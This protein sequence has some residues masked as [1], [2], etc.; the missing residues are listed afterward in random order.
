MDVCLFN[1]NKWIHIFLLHC[2]EN[3]NAK[4]WPIFRYEGNISLVF[5]WKIKVDWLNHLKIFDLML[6][7]CLVSLDGVFVVKLFFE[8]TIIKNFTWNLEF[9]TFSR[10]RQTFIIIHVVT[11]TGQKKF[12]FS[13]YAIFTRRNFIFFQKKKIVITLIDHIFR[14]PVEIST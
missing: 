12:F 4:D 5:W 11:L 8:R 13:L 6:L 1:V 7:N 2:F 14:N 3:Q 10:G 9:S